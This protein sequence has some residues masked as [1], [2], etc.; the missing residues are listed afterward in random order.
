MTRWIK[1]VLTS[2]F[3]ILFFLIFAC[4]VFASNS[5]PEAFSGFQRPMVNDHSGYIFLQYAKYPTGWVW[6]PGWDYN[7]SGS[8][9]A[10]KGT[11]VVSVAIGKVISAPSKEPKVWGSLVIQHLYKGEFVYSQFGHMQ[12]VFVSVGDIVDKGQKIGEM[13]SVKADS[14]HLHW[15]IRSANHPDPDN[16]KYWNTKAFQD[17]DKVQRWYYNPQYWVDNHGPYRNEKPGDEIEKVSKEFTEAWYNYDTQTSKDYLEKIK[18][19]MTKYFY[20]MT[21]YI[22][23]KRLKDFKGQVPTRSKILSIK[24]LSFSDNKTQ[25]EIVRESYELTTHRQYKKKIILDLIKEDNKWLVSY[26]RP[27]L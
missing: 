12:K 13:G 1:V 5:V 22:N 9:N 23:T 15:E 2:I 17:K 3:T 14:A 27:V 11:V 19:Y 25:T 18:P 7:G 16:A 20:E 4:Q 24:I 21:Y 10:D 26:L 8:G 6:P